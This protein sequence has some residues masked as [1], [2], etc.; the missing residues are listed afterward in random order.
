MLNPT[1]N[2]NEPEYEPIDLYNAIGDK[3]GLF[4]DE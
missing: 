4:E 1:A 3:L 2:M